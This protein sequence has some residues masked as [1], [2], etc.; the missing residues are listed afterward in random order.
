MTIPGSKDA[1]QTAVDRAFDA[2]IAKIFDIFVQGIL[3]KSPRAT[4]IERA[5]HGFE[6]AVETHRDLLLMVDRFFAEHPEC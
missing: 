6:A 1:A 2:E 4:L 3:L 5:G